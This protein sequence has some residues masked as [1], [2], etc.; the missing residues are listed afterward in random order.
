MTRCSGD[1]RARSLDLLAY[2]VV[3]TCRLLVQ[4]RAD[5]ELHHHKQIWAKDAHGGPYRKVWYS[6]DF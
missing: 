4:L 1:A 3:P 2:I 5:Q 6:I